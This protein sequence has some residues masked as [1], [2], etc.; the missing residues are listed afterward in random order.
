MSLVFGVG[1]V[2]F[3]PRGRNFGEPNSNQIVDNLSFGS[4]ISH[5]FSEDWTLTHRFEAS[6]NKYLSRGTTVAGF[7]P[8]VP[9]QLD[10]QSVAFAV[11]DYVFT[12]NLDLS[13]KFETFGVKHTVLIGG[14]FFSRYNH[15][16]IS[17]PWLP[18]S[19]IDYI[20]P[21]HSFN[22]TDS[23]QFDKLGLQGIASHGRNRYDWYGAYVQ[24]HIALPYN[25]FVLAGAR[26]DHAIYHDGG[27]LIYAGNVLSGDGLDHTVDNSQRVTPR[28]GLLWRPMPEVSVYGSYLENFGQ[29]AGTSGPSRTPLPPETA[30]GWEVGVKTELFDKRLSVSLD[31]FN[32]TKQHTAAPD[33]DPAR[34][35]LGYQV[36]L[37]ETRNKGIEFDAAGEILPGWKA[38]ASYAYI[39][40]LITKDSAYN[41]FDP[42]GNLLSV[43]GYQ[44]FSQ[45]GVSRHMGSLWTTYEFQ[46][47]DW[48]GL[49][50]GGG[51]NFRSKSYADLLNSF[52]VP[53]YATVGLMASYTWTLNGNKM[54]A[55]LNVDNLLD[56]RYY[57]EAS[58]GPVS[59][60]VGEPR[61][62]K[63][64]ISMEF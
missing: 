15:G 38:I 59:V 8:T 58:S 5:K 48:K 56:T 12:T 26:Y 4:N 43:N 36:S 14:D 3:L 24:D 45:P 19:T 61:T 29:N 30:Q 40:S 34:A 33:P 53:S 50:F 7:D 23:A 16:D 35:A 47:S 39:E 20:F 1:P 22:P 32:L 42:L 11:N 62:F 51:S 27:S 41:V 57:T 21:I 64:S 54:T 63:G 9:T 52:H 46:N 18:P 10:R 31:Y 55:Q 13:G 37:G 17:F 6:L 28:F 44:G 2:S 25:F 60:G 49:K